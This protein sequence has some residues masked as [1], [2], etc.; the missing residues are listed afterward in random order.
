M[1][2]LQGVTKTY[3]E[4]IFSLIDLDL[5]YLSCWLPLISYFHTRKN[6]TQN[7]FP[8]KSGDGVAVWLAQDNFDTALEFDVILSDPQHLGR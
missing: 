3:E 4:F 2:C 6:T 7:P 8:Q 5:Q 1:T